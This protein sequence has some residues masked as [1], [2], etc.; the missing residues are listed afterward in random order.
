MT[1]TPPENHTNTPYEMKDIIG[2]PEALLNELQQVKVENEVLKSKLQ[3]ARSTETTR[4]ALHIT[5]EENAKLAAQLQQAREEL[6]GVDEHISKLTKLHIDEVVKSTN[7]QSQLS[8]WQ[9]EFEKLIRCLRAIQMYCEGD[10]MYNKT[11]ISAIRASIIDIISNAES[12]LKPQTTEAR[13]EG[14]QHTY[15]GVSSRCT[16]CGG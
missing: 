1:N 13:K 11:D 9:E 10:I 4:I 5:E 16:K 15:D 7:L 12:L 8:Q 14:C 2:L 6:A 3:I